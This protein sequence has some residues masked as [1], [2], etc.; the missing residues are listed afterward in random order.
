VTIRDLDDD[1]VAVPTRASLV[2]GPQPPVELGV[3]E[4]LWR[5]GIDLAVTVPCS[6]RPDAPAP[7]PPCSG[8]EIAERFGRALVGAAPA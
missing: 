6:E 5:H 3:L 8:R 7:V 4:A 2:P 1:S